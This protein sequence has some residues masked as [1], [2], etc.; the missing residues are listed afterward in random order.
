MLR[1]T[2]IPSAPPH[3][4]G[5]VGNGSPWCSQGLAVHWLS[6]TFCWRTEFHWL[7][8]YTSCCWI[9]TY[10]Y[11]ISDSLSNQFLLGWVDVGCAPPSYVC[12]LK[13]L[14]AIPM[15]AGHFSSMVS[16]FC[17]NTSCEITNPKGRH[18]NL[19]H[20]NSELNVVS[21]ELAS[22]NLMDQYPFLWL[23]C[24]RQMLQTGDWWFLPGLALYGMDVS[25]PNF[26]WIQ[27]DADAPILLLCVYEAWHT[28]RGLVCLS[29]YT[30]GFHFVQLLFNFLCCMAYL[31]LPNTA[32]LRLREYFP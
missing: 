7:G 8:W 2:G 27:T 21:L 16:I 18:R 29:N 5:Q 13:H 20:L 1:C 32:G 6:W 3:F 23:F 15:H 4:L 14:S 26:L 22:S 28:T 19:C 30:H 12:T 17:W 9:S 10:C 24:W 31:Y 25:G 11:W